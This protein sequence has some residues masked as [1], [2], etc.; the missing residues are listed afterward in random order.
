[1]LEPELINE[2]AGT[3]HR[4]L[5]ER[6]TVAPLTESMPGID[7]DDAYKISRAFLNLREAEGERVVGTHWP[8]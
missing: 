6:T 1:M 2:A 7:V 3:L 8:T 4:C 5:R